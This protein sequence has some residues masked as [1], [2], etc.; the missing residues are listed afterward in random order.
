MK[1]VGDTGGKRGQESERNRDPCDDLLCVEVSKLQHHSGND[2]QH[3]KQHSIG[4][5]TVFC[6]ATLNQFSEA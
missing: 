1:S 4:C 2:A 3:N 5:K 6:S